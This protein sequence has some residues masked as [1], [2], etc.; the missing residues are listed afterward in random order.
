MTA[1]Q[2]AEPSGLWQYHAQTQ[3]QAPGYA[4]PPP[5][6]A[7]QNY[8][9]AAEQPSG[10]AVGQPPDEPSQFSAPGYQPPGYEPGGYAQP[11]YQEPAYQEPSYQPAVAPVAYPETAY[12][13]AVPTPAYQEPAYPQAAPPPAYQEQA[14][15]QPAYPQP[16]YGQAAFTPGVAAA[17]GAYPG[18]GYPAAPG[19]YPGMPGYGQQFDY[20]AAPIKLPAVWPVVGFTFLLWPVGAVS[21]ARRAKRAKA[22]GVSGSRYWI[23]FV[24]TIVVT[25]AAAFAIGVAMGIAQAATEPAI[26]SGWLEASIVE[27]GD[28]KDKS[29]KAIKAS[30]A[31]CTA[32]K[33]DGDGAG[34]YRCMI[35]FSNKTRQT[36]EVTV[37]GTGRWVTNGGN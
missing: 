2:Q 1:D 12:S 24:A 11:A 36:F 6:V 18:Q 10:Y 9:Y 4:A 27:H 30:A 34:S 23:A 13:P 35:D 25:W 21:A 22:A 29:G 8:G 26:T 17:P 14:A 3:D 20:L 7:D 37:D 31:T 28:F 19:G 5:P 33:V 16:G 32:F 15:P